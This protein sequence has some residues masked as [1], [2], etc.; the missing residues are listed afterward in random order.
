[1]LLQRLLICFIALLFASQTIS[2]TIDEHSVHK[3]IET[4]LS[5][6]TSHQHQQH[7]TPNTTT[8]V[9]HEDVNQ[10]QFN[11]HDCGHCHT[12]VNVF[13]V[14]ITGNLNLN[15][16]ALHDNLITPKFTSALIFPEH[17]PPIA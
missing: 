13:L 15:K 5:S 14:S 3:N 4:H 2:A 17:R 12:P 1:M 6:D 11:C 7:K 16:N 9:M 8:S 10:E